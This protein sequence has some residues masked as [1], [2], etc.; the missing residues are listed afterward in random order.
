MAVTRCC[1]TAMEGSAS[2]S[3]PPSPPLAP[4][5]CSTS[6][7][8]TLWQTSGVESERF[9]SGVCLRFA[10][11]VANVWGGKR[12]FHQGS[13]CVLLVSCQPL[14]W[15][16]SVVESERF[17]QGSVCVLLVLCLALLPLLQ[18]VSI[19]LP[20]LP[21]H[22]DRGKRNKQTHILVWGNF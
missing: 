1:C 14:L 18:S 13:V 5:T 9:L 8:S 15:Q 6:M 12:S 19:T 7:V 3:P 17:H 2:P 10:F 11:L 21:F 20:C 16:T 4:S 22:G